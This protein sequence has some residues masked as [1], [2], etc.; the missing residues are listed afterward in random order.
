MKKSIITIISL[1]LTNVCFAHNTQQYDKNTSLAVIISLG[2]VTS[3]IIIIRSIYWLII[4]DIYKLRN[5]LNF[6]IWNE[7]EDF[8]PN[9]ITVLFIIFNGLVLFIYLVNY[10]NGIL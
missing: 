2:I 8:F 3:V 9:V 10:I 5:Y 1:L 7:N 4:T 6:A